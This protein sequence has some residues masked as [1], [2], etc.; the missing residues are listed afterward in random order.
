MGLK[1]TIA[2]MQTLLEKISKDLHKSIK[3]NKAA[4]QRVRTGTINL[5]K[6]GKIYRKESIR[7]EKKSAKK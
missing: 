7:Q 1:D 6:I 4:S 5:S 2:T 3:G